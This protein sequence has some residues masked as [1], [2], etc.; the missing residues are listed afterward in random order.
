MLNITDLLGSRDATPRTVRITGDDLVARS[1]IGLKAMQMNLELLRELE[2]CPEEYKYAEKAWPEFWRSMVKQVNDEIADMT[3]VRDHSVLSVDV[4]A[5]QARAFAQSLR[6]Q[7]VREEI[8]AEL[9]KAI[10]QD[11]REHLNRQGASE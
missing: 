6:K 2:A 8:K 11:F 1:E 4:T 3:F 5:D 10:A 7:V 9:D